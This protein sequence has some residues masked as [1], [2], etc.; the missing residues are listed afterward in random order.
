MLDADDASDGEA[1]KLVLPGGL[2]L[3]L[4]DG[5]EGIV[6]LQGAASDPTKGGD[7]F[8]PKPTLLQSPGLSLGCT[9]A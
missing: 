9:R 8:N 6:S 2:F 3:R 4:E 7:V 5:Q 1:E